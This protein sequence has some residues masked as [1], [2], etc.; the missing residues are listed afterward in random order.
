MR[1]LILERWKGAWR[2]LQQPW[3]VRA[4]LFAFGCALILPG[5]MFAALGIIAF[6]SSDRA[7]R[8]VPRSK[9]PARRA[10]ISIAT[11]RA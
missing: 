10:M 3:P 9:L 8:T 11:S 5:L 6:R 1:V 2:A 4:Y 7:A